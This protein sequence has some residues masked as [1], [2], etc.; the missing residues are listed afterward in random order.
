MKRSSFSGSE[1]R[2]GCTRPHVLFDPVRRGEPADGILRRTARHRPQRDRRQDFLEELL[3]FAG[4]MG[5][6]RRLAVTSR[7]CP[8]Y[9]VR[10]MNR[11]LRLA[12]LVP[13][14]FPAVG[15]FSTLH[16]FSGGDRPFV[17]ALS[18]APL[19]RHGVSCDDRFCLEAARRVA[20][21]ARLR[22]PQPKQ[23]IRHV[24][25]IARTVPMDLHDP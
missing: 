19:Q 25:R 15:R 12:S 1:R 7:S 21:L 17:A 10:Q 13:P 22:Y 24:A 11:D 14:R 18:A 8:R 23:R 6:A 2:V 3:K 16:K 5:S 20:E 4:G 9:R